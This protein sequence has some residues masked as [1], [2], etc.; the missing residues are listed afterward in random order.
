MEELQW[1][2][3]ILLA[4]I[5]L[6]VRMWLKAFSSPTSTSSNRPQKPNAYPVP[7]PPATSYQDILKEMQAAEKRAK[8]LEQPVNRESKSQEARSLEK[9]NI[10]ARSLESLAVAPKQKVNTS[11]AKEM[12]RPTKKSENTI[13]PPTVNY[14]KLLR[15]PQNVRTAFILSE[16]L[17]RRVDF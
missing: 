4:V 11:L 12:A 2:F 6:V 1:L 17:N 3:F 9:T 10:P 16:I 13:V 15:N 7:A 5:V 8:N 14:N